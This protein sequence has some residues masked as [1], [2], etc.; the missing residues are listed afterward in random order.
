M[1]G[2]IETFVLIRPRVVLLP[3]WAGSLALFNV[4]TSMST[5]SAPFDK[6]HEPGA[7]GHVPAERE[8]DE[9]GVRM[10]VGKV[11]IGTGYS[12][13]TPL[14]ALSRTRLTF[15]VTFKGS[16]RCLVLIFVNDAQ[17]QAQS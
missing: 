1:P 4:S 14:I 6:S 13:S 16:E 17:Y 9:G 3:E 11:R 15:S 5:F 8:R 7:I 10:L 12:S 2:T